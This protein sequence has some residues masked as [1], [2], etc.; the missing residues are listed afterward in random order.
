MNR[1][2]IVLDAVGLTP[3]LVGGDTP[4]LQKL[5][6]ATGLHSLETPFPALTLSGQAGILTGATPARHGIVGNGWYWRD[7]EEVL[8]W[9]QPHRLLLC[10]DLP[11][12]LRRERPGFR[13]AKLFFWYALYAPVDWAVT[14]RPMYPAD[15]RKIPDLHTHPPELRRELQERFGPFPLFRFWGPAAGLEATEWI[16][17]AARHL[18]A[19][20]RPDLALVYLPHLDYD[21][22]RHGPDSQEARRALRELD[23]VIGDFAGFASS[24]GARLLILSEYGITPA[25]RALHPNRWL[26]D[27]GLLQVRDELGTERLDFGASRAFA[28]SDHQ[29]AHVYVRAPGDIPR[30][31]HLFESQPGVE[32]VLE[33]PGLAREGLAHERSGEL[34]LVSERDAWFTYYFWLDDARA[35]DYARTVDIHRKPGYDPAEL[36]LD[37]LLRWPRARIAWRL[38]RRRLGFRDL[39]D[40]IGLDASVV[41]GSHGRRPDR[42]EDGAI[43][44]PPEPLR[45]KPQGP[46]PLA[47]LPGLIAGWCGPGR[48][49]G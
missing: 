20:E 16:S 33:G 19:A 28:V 4:S 1:P 45:E 24:E 48:G 25:R 15:G 9:R 32:R 42:P 36:V 21:F 27:A 11:T 22:Q 40:V 46:I 23:Q 38:L 43:L 35:P 2:L 44:I 26:R 3:G 14:P 41:K 5:A 31:R 30:V 12:R 7:L 29:I 34:V 49:T 18:I 39:L 6:A 10:E 8:F 17:A 13:V 47:S 37:P